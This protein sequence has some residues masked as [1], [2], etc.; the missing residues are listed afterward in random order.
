MNS[1]AFHTE[2]VQLTGFMVDR[3]VG[4]ILQ[5]PEQIGILAEAFLKIKTSSHEDRAIWNFL[6]NANVIK[7]VG[8]SDVGSAETYQLNDEDEEY[9]LQDETGVID[10]NVK[11][12]AECVVGKSLG[13]L[14]AQG[15]EKK[16][17]APLIAAFKSQMKANFAEHSHLTESKWLG[18]R[19]KRDDSGYK[20]IGTTP[21]DKT[22]IAQMDAEINAVL[23]DAEK[24]SWDLKG[25][26]SLEKKANVDGSTSKETQHNEDEEHDQKML[27][28]LGDLLKTRYHFLLDS[29]VEAKNMP[30]FLC[31]AGQFATCQLKGVQ[32]KVGLNHVRGEVERSSVSQPV[33]TFQT[34][35]KYNDLRKLNQLTVGTINSMDIPNRP[36]RVWVAQCCELIRMVSLQTRMYFAEM[37]KEWKRLE[38]I[39]TEYPEEEAVGSVALCQLRQQCAHQRVLDLGTSGQNGE[40]L[41]STDVTGR[42]DVK[43][44]LD[45]MR[46]ATPSSL[47]LSVPRAGMSSNDTRLAPTR[48]Y[49]GSSGDS[50]A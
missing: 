29:G 1:K 13:I 34:I 11:K 26:V 32:I 49:S 23:R 36:W 25:I 10:A 50:M 27:N 21:Y 19:H 43:G 42:N 18:M 16:D 31:T 17:N 47:L 8:T 39:K 12:L 24:A 46:K 35:G 4:D 37:T 41:E 15:A 5:N 45:G 40:A 33:Y 20:T 6:L 7:K 44:V 2:R 9:A 28:Q 38:R 48:R 22:L 3:L 14:Q 30:P